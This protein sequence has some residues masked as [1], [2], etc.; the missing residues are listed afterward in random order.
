MRDGRIE[1]DPGVAVTGEKAR[2]LER[3]V[4]LAGDVVA[5]RRGELGR[6]ALVREAEEGWLCGTG[7]LRI[8]P[9]SQVLVSQY[10]VLILGSQGVRDMLSL[11]SI[12]ATMDNLNAAMVARLR[13]ACPSLQEQHEIL[14]YIESEMA[15]IRS[16]IVRTQRQIDL[17]RE[18]RTRLI[19]DVV[20]GKLDVREAAAHLPEE[21]EDAAVYDEREAPDENDEQPLADPMEETE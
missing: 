19:A 2:E 5:A 4:L 14:N 15:K 21:A 8:R 12:G 16:A 17:I 1:L 10:L 9:K 6:C 13:L 3:H 11:S 7:S 20:T 18:Y